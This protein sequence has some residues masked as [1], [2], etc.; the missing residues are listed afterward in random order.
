[1]ECHNT[2]GLSETMG[3]GTI[4][5]RL[6]DESKIGAI[7]KPGLLWDARIVDGRD[8]DVPQGE[9]GEIIVKGMGVMKEYYKNPELTRGP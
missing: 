7:G 5:N 9:V 4:H 1:M 3:P 6:D 2:Y 8:E